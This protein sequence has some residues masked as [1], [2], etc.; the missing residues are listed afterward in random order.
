MMRLSRP[1]L[2]FSGKLSVLPKEKETWGAMLILPLASQVSLPGERPAL[3]RLW[4]GA[5][6]Y[7]EVLPDFE[8]F[9]S[10]AASFFCLFDLGA[11]FCSFFCFCSL[12]A[13]ECGPPFKMMSEQPAR[14][15]RRCFLVARFVPEP[16]RLSSASSLKMWPVW[17]GFACGPL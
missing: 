6:L 11:A 7:T 4:E 2:A 17:S 1:F 12:F 15:K 14:R 13:M 10:R 9:F 8:A 16:F 3:V 5:W